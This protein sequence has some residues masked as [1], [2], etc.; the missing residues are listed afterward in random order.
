MLTSCKI[1]KKS[2]EP[3]LSN[4]Q[5]SLF[6]SQK[7]PKNGQNWQNV[8]FLKNGLGSTYTPWWS[9]TLCKISKKSNESI[10]SN[11]QK[12]WFCPTVPPNFAPFCR[13]FWGKGIF[14][15]KWE[16]HLKRLTVFY[17]YSKKYKKTVER[18]KK[19]SNLKNRAIWLVESF[20]I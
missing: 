2:N 10:L 6:F 9:L 17:L 4:I 3:I 13:V 15:E 14:P 7:G 5:E 19:Y 18:F 1:S 8:F 20:C 12:S 16:Q 11:I